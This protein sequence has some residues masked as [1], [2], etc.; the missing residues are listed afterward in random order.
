MIPW[1][2]SQN[3]K[4]TMAG[5]NIP[6]YYAHCIFPTMFF[7]YEL[8]GYMVSAGY[9]CEA[10]TEFKGSWDWE[11]LISFQSM[12]SLLFKTNSRDKISRQL[13]SFH[14]LFRFY[15]LAKTAREKR[16]ISWT[17]IIYARDWTWH[18]ALNSNCFSKWQMNV[19]L[20]HEKVKF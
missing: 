4:F 20:R 5:H 12:F 1:F 8:P 16:T 6:S 10:W 14:M 3:L 18:L 13:I 7:Y 17:S 15:Y 9:I 19:V 2:T 11:N